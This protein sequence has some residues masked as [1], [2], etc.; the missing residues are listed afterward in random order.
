[1]RRRPKA[2]PE[3]SKSRRGKANTQKRRGGLKTTCLRNSS[4]ADHKTQSDVVQLT[5]ERDEALEREKK[6][7]GEKIALELLMI[8]EPVGFRMPSAKPLG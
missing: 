2:G 3:R 1:M 4:V 6:S 5:R 7:A 8:A